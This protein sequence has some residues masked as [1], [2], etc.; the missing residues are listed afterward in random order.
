MMQHKIVEALKS[1]KAY[2]EEVSQIRFLQTH[3]SYVFMTGKN[4][5]KIKKP[6]NFGFLDF[7]TLESRKYYCEEE[8][9]L[10]RRLCGDMYISVLPIA[11]SDDIIKIN[12]EGKVVEYTLKMKEIPQNTIMSKLLAENKVSKIDVER[13]AKLLFD[14]HN[15]AETNEEIEKYGSLDVIRFNWNENFDQAREFIGRTIS[16]NIFCFIYQKVNRFMEEKRALFE[17]RMRKRRIRDCHGDLHSANIF[18]ADRIY[19]F[20]AIEFNKR[21]RYSDVASE[22]AFLT[23][24]LDFLNKQDLS[25]FF[26]NKYLDYSGDKELLDMLP[27]YKCYRAFVRGKV[28][29]FK[30]NDPTLK[31]ADKRKSEKSAMKYFKLSYECA[32]GLN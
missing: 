22:I 3:I 12:G 11:L 10:N 25:E 9:R 32:K 2:D 30:L 4:A 21:F 24:D 18:I 13:I 1:P 28:T 31:K 8:L 23:M 26:Q 19:I 7:T 15:K 6:V 5:Y 14:F 27:F 29:S 20:D 17:N 16:D